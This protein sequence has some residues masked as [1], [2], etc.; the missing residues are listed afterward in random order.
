LLPKECLSFARDGARVLPEWLGPRDEP[1]IRALAGAVEEARASPRGEALRGL[2]LRAGSL[3]RTHGRAPAAGRGALHVLLAERTWEAPS[4]LPARE[5]RLYLWERV[6][7]RGREAGLAEAAE[8]FGVS[9]PEVLAALFADQPERKLLADAAEA[10][11]PSVVAA[12]HNLWLAQALVARALR[13]EVAAHEHARSVVSYAKLLRLMVV[14]RA[15]ASGFRV[16]I[17]GPLALVRS[18]RKYGLAL[19]R[20]V[21]AASALPAWRLDAI[22]DLP[23][24]P[25]LLELDAACPLERRHALPRETD[26]KLEARL[27]ADFR[28]LG[29]R[30][31]LTREPIALRLGA[32]FAFPDFVARADGARVIVE[33]VGFYTRDYLE[34]K[35]RTY[36]ASD[37]PLVLCVDEA[38]ADEVP[39]GRF[40]VVTFRRRIDAARL[41]RAIDAAAQRSKGSTSAGRAPAPS[42]GPAP[43]VAPSPE[44]APAP[45]PPESTLELEPAPELEPIG[46]PAPLR[47]GRTAR[48]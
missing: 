17:L 32:T 47:T 3:A 9:E 6:A 37:V 38:A 30:Y 27:V 46:P 1:W 26:S 28:A 14:G 7:E 40:E 29:S 16:E 10:L 15:A 34:K 12:R 35:W 43:A 23:E 19:A 11:A 4:D 41:L 13:V 24:G 22:L 44:L 18:T 8:R 45:T 2:A 36:A 33:I 42:P 25:T 5:L 21:G 48:G 31:S 20:L 39:P